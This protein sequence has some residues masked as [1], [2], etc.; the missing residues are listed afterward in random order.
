MAMRRGR[1]TATPPRKPETAADLVP[2]LRKHAIKLLDRGDGA[3]ANWPLI[4]EAAL[5]I[6]F[7]AL[8]QVPNDPR[9]VKLLRRVHSGAEN[10]SLKT[11][12]MNARPSRRR[13]RQPGATPIRLHPPTRRTVLP[14]PDYRN[15]HSG[16][17][18]LHNRYAQKGT[19][20]RGPEAP[21]KPLA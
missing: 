9:T 10:R 7:D 3:A 2:L 5:K 11:L 17:G 12:L 13:A 4:A 8:D 20:S 18:K 16:E 21:R 15:R 1:S 19:L 6:A 14:T